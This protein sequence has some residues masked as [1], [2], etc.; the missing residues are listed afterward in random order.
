MS[1][2]QTKPENLGLALI[3][4]R[5]IVEETFHRLATKWRKETMF[6]SSPRDVFVDPV[7]LQIIGMGEEIVP[8][9][10]EETQ[11]K[12]GDWFLALRSITRQDPTNEEDAGDVVKMG[13][14]WL[15]WARDQGYDV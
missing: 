2:E 15:R 9:L 6:K 8:L 1:I 13:E 3:G 10:L 4:P 5:P 14:A 11:R 7:Y 12:P